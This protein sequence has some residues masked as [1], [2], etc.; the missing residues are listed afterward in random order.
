MEP[1]ITSK[2]RLRLLRNE[3]ALTQKS[4]GKRLG[5][6]WYQIKDMESGKVKIS[7]TIAK[8]VKYETGYNY[9]WLLFGTGDKKSELI[10]RNSRVLSRVIEKTGAEVDDKEKDFLLEIINKLFSNDENRVE[11][12]FSEMFKVMRK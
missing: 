2:E 6:S 4:L 10:D 11:D 12:K 1:P 9:E 3:L 5:L 8:L 7:P